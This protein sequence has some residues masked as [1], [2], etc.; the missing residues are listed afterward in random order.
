MARFNNQT[1]ADNQTSQHSTERNETRQSY[2]LSAFAM[3]DKIFN[4]I[5]EAKHNKL[6]V[7]KFRE[8][9]E[10]IVKA[11]SGMDVHFIRNAEFYPDLKETLSKIYYHI[12]DSSTRNK[13]VKMMMAKKDLATY[14]E[15]QKHVDNLVSRIV[16]SYAQ[17]I[18]QRRNSPSPS[19][20]RSRSS[21]SGCASCCA[22]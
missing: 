2:S 14:G 1:G 12:I 20:D 7:V 3:F 11:L 17:R 6:H 8:I 21:S 18:K 9:T 5:S 4:A 10:Q 15:I 22:E 13:W 16:F 19:S